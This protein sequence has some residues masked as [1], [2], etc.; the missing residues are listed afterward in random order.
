MMYDKRS[1]AIPSPIGVISS[2]AGAA[3]VIRYGNG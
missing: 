1:A 3:L 2:Y